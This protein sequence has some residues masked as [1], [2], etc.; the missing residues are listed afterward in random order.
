MQGELRMTNMGL[1]QPPAADGIG[2]PTETSNHA[3]QTHE[4]EGPVLYQRS[5]GEKAGHFCGGRLSPQ[6]LNPVEVRSSQPL[7]VS[8]PSANSLGK[9]SGSVSRCDMASAVM[10]RWSTAL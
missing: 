10:P 9:M 4:P 8:C 3:C 2:C 7:A 5:V 6:V 1:R